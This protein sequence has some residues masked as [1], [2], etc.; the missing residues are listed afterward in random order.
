MQNNPSFTSLLHQVRKVCLDAYGNQDL[1]F[2]KLVE[3]LQPERNLIHTP[4]FP[5][6]VCAAKCQKVAIELPGI[7]CQILETESGVAKFDLTLAMEEASTGIKGEWEYNRD[8]FDGARIRQMI[9]HLQVLLEAVVSNPQQG[10]DQLP[11]LTDRERQQLLLEWNDTSIDYSLNKCVHELF[12]EQV[13]RTPDAVA[14]EFA[15]LQLTYEELNN[16]ANQLAN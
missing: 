9:G 12:E 4:L 3:V 14:V 13:E 6:N 16:R 8:L 1:P 11:L 2:E 15:E 5:G 10:I 7:N